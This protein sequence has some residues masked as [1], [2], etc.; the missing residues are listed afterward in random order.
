M[1]FRGTSAELGNDVFGQEFGIASRDVN[2]GVFYQEKRFKN[3]SEFFHFLHFIDED[4][5]DFVIGNLTFYC[6]HEHIRIK[7]VLVTAVLKVIKKYVVRRD[8]ISDE[9]ILEDVFQQI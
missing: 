5:V 7:Q 1:D 9:P 8:A 6:V 4:E 3:L 2:L